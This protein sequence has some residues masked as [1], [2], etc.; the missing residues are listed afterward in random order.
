MVFDAEEQE[1]HLVKRGDLVEFSDDG[2]EWKR[3]SYRF[4]EMVG[5]TMRFFN[6]KRGFRFMR[7]RGQ[8]VN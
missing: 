7:V 6:R 1:V 3:G 8:N 5:D 4:S 2:L